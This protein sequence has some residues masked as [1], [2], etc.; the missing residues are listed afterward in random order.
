MTE[1]LFETALR[2]KVRFAH[3]GQISVEDLWDLPVITLDSMY[4]VEM[5]H[6]KARSTDSLLEKATVESETGQ[7]RIDILKYVIKAKLNEDK[8]R[9]DSAVNKMKKDKL[10]AIIAK[11]QDEGLENMSIEDLEKAIAELS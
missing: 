1:K 8:A 4:G 11:K 9:K 7:L 3:K 2:T 10:A 6:H 5:T